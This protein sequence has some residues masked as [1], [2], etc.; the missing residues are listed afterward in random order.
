MLYVAGTIAYFAYRLPLWNR[1]SPVFSGLMLFAELFGVLTLLLHV[2]STWTL[3]ERRAPPPPSDYEADI[4]ITTF[5][6][7]VEILRNT[8]LAAMQVRHARAVW[9]LDDGCRQPAQAL[10]RELAPDYS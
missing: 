5:N 9:L 6:E 1:A 7:P 2:F 10:A 8:L 4:L 3:V